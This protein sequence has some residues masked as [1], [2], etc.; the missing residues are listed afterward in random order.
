MPN[1]VWDVITFPFRNFNGYTFEVNFTLYTLLL[2]RDISFPFTHRKKFHKS[3]FAYILPSCKF[4]LLFENSLRHAARC[5]S[6]VIFRCLYNCKI[7]TKCHRS[8][9][10]NLHTVPL[11]TCH[12][13]V[14]TERLCT[15]TQIQYIGGR[16][17]CRIYE[18]WLVGNNSN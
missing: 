6:P 1:I 8:A 15:T 13:T 4:M 16:G 12:M 10:S 17:I 3:N 7:V 11:W 2:W 18:I 5:V 9:S 14:S